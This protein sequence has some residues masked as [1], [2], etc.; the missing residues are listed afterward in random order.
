MISI[1]L[2]AD[3]CL[4]TFFSRIFVQSAI[5]MYRTFTYAEL[6][7]RFCEGFA[8]FP[9][10]ALEQ[11][12]H[13]IYKR[14]MAGENT[15]GLLDSYTGNSDGGLHGQIL[16]VKLQQQDIPLAAELLTRIQSEHSLLEERFRGMKR[17]P[18]IYKQLLETMDS[19]H[20][21]LSVYQH[22]VQQQI[23]AQL[24]ALTDKHGPLS[25]EGITAEN[26]ANISSVVQEFLQST[27]ILYGFL[28]GCIR[29]M[30]GFKRLVLTARETEDMEI[31]LKMVR[32]F[33]ALQRKT[34]YVLEQW[35]E[36]GARHREQ[37]TMN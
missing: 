4:N 23:V 20:R 29:Q 22:Q 30:P 19:Y 11:H 5:V 16:L 36:E 13:F 10:T 3:H 31:L 12:G 2:D 15:A 1:C 35:K 14:Y 9:F 21:I 6:L 34:S 17:R 26:L 25:L 18:A 37:R 32:A 7:E 33:R 28:Y 27:E 8:F 24:M